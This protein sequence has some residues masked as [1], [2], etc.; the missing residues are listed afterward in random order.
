[1]TICLRADTFSS[2]LWFLNNENDISNN[3]NSV[4]GS[5]NLNAKDI[6]Y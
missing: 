5:R 6:P 3:I 2:I 4:V 1:M